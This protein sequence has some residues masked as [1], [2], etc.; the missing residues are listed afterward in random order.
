MPAAAEF[1]GVGAVHRPACLLI[2]K[3]GLGADVASGTQ[4]ELGIFALAKSLL[5]GL[6]ADGQWRL[7]RRRRRGSPARRPTGRSGIARGDRPAVLAVIATDL[8]F[9]R[10]S[11]LQ[12]VGASG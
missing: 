11:F 5:A 10:L 9:V 3:R 6:I 4:R 8:L 1:A 12:T 7:V 2:V